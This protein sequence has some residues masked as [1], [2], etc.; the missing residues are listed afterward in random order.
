MRPSIGSGKSNGPDSG[1]ST[2]P[3]VPPGVRALRGLL[4]MLH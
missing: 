2:G 4:P 1:T 3:P